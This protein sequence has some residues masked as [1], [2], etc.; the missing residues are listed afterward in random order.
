MELL[1]TLAKKTLE[2]RLI[3]IVT[4]H[5]IDFLSVNVGHSPVVVDFNVAWDTGDTTT[6]EAL[7][8]GGL[9]WLPVITRLD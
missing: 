5:K 1:D 2:K 7:N 3:K 6:G 8:E 4:W 9:A